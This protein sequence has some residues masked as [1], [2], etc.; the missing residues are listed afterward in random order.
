MAKQKPIE[1]LT[2]EK[3]LQELDE[4]LSSLEAGDLDLEETI[5]LYERGKQLLG[6]CRELLEQAQLRVSELSPEGKLD[7]LE[8]NS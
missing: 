1:E 4:V 5:A 2:Y 7:H 6:R 3:S 8:D